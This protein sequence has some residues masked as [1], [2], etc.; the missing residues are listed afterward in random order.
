MIVECAQCGQANRIPANKLNSGPRC[1]KC[2]ATFEGEAIRVSSTNDFDELV[3]GS[4]L[5]IVVD[6]WA[7]WCGPCKAIAPELER[8]AK[9]RSGSIVIAKVDT[10]ALPDLAERYRIRSIPTMLLFSSGREAKRITGAMP[11]NQIVSALGL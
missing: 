7:D 1:G 4:P 6:F 9:E 10:E 3:A 11:A 8:L 5:P 2:K